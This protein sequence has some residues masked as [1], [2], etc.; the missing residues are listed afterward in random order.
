MSNHHV[1]FDVE[2]WCL[3]ESKLHLDRLGQTESLFA[4][5]NGH[6]GLRGNLDEGE[7]HALPGSYLNGFYELRSLP[8]AEAGYGYPESG[9]TVINVT[10]GKI[11]RLLAGDEPFDVRYGTLRSHERVLDF[12]DGVLRR[13]VEWVSPAGRV[14]RVESTRI[15]SFNHRAVAA[16]RFSVTPLDGPAPVTVQSELIANEEL[17][18]SSGDPRVAAQLDRPLLPEVHGAVGTAVELVH[19]T[20]A[21]GLHVAVGMHNVVDAPVEPQMVTDCHEDIGRVTISASLGQGETLTLTK[22]VGYGW[23]SVRSIPAV[24]DQVIAAVAAAHND[25]WDRM[26]EAQ[27]EYLDDFWDHAD[28]E[29]EGDEQIQQAV[30]FALFHMLQAS[31]RAEGQG[32]PAK[33]LTGP[34]YDG[35][36]FW[37]TETYVLPVLNY[38]AHRASSHALTWR[39]DTL[40]MAKERASQ[41]R[42]AGAAFPWRTINGEECSGYWPAG[43]AAF[44]IGADI[45]AAVSRCIATDADPE[46]RFEREYGL[47]ILVETARLWRALGHFDLEGEFR[48]DGVTGPDEYS[49]VA[50]NN[51]FTNLMAQQNLRDAAAVAA[52]NADRQEELGFDDDEIA[53][54]VAAA[55][56][57]RVPFDEQ[58]GIYPQAEGFT[59]YEVWDFEG[60][61]ADEYPLL[62]NFPYFDLYRKQVVKQADL[63]L[64]LFLRGDAFTAE[65]KL[66][67]FDYYEGL[68]VRDSSLSPCIQA[69]VAAE[70]GHLE[71]AHDY[72]H[73]AALMDLADLAHNT[74]DGLHLASL[75][76]TWLALVNGMGGLRDHGGHLSFRPR[77]P[78][79]LQRISFNL[80]MQGSLLH[81][82]L[83]GEQAVYTVTDGPALEITHEDETFTVEPGTPEKRPL[84][85]LPDLEEPS[86]PAGRPPRTGDL[87]EP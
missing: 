51:I 66:A 6:I 16:F 3:R 21:S 9:Q 26:L 41:L 38:T 43:T 62:L 12:R 54:W 8:Y 20:R 64:A 19:T 25:G 76:G 60:T 80:G 71:L 33:G 78:S 70:V 74:G 56:A 22:Y 24:R 4:L 28:V 31:A 30:R 87:V 49:A 57:M 75:A 32:I 1:P 5:S 15:V 27:R 59:R 37:D 7:P 68:T 13:S 83:D 42:L 73:E 85:K 23:S 67:N 11:I 10:N 29:V 81:V 84:A 86:Q 46:R 40:P 69:V 47:E 34:G 44:H 35:H 52:R 17:P 50:D 58:L 79:G 55:D 61:D 39:H 53:G 77:M 36:A 63:V 45:A 65:E 72:L 2:P 48:L 82:A 18:Q 14:F